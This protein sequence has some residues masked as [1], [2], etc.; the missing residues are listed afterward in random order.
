MVNSLDLGH[1]HGYSS[2]NSGPLKVTEQK[3]WLSI[4]AAQGSCVRTAPGWKNNEKS[5]ELVPFTVLSMLF[6]TLCSLPLQPS[7]VTKKGASL[8]DPV[9]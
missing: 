5:V 7:N 2:C 9:P 1:F 8:L 3:N 4:A 6:I